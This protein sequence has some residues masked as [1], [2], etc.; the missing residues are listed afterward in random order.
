MRA[1]R[2]ML[3]VALPLSLLLH[4]AA[5]VA[6]HYHGGAESRTQGAVHP[7]QPQLVAR[8]SLAAPLAQPIAESVEPVTGPVTE[9]APPVPKLLPEP[10]HPPQP[11]P[12][13]TRSQ[14]PAPA[15][16]SVER[17]PI[18]SGPEPVNPS[19]REEVATAAPDALPVASEID[20]AAE[21]V[22]REALWHAYLDELRAHI[23]ANRHYDQAA[24]RRRIEG[25]VGVSFRLLPDGRVAALQLDSVQR[26]LTRSAE[27]TMAASLPLPPPPADMTDPRE[28]SF[29][30]VYALR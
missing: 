4:A 17:A 12:K 1:E 22:A 3:V 6:W 14:T 19:G 7:S 13:P 10:P 30:L 18:P 2:F 5:F 16:V 26:L 11:R 23:E 29:E 28:I 27:Q 20:S 9:L 24:R 25:R 8:L 21:S 15:P